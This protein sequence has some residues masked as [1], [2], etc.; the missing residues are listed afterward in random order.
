[1]IWTRTLTNTVAI[2]GSLAE[3]LNDKCEAQDKCEQHNCQTP[4]QINNDLSNS[5]WKHVK[6]NS[7]VKD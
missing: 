3:Q 4:F 7:G 1:M 6:A 2:A 5:H